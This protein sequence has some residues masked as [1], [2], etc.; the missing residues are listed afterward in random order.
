MIDDFCMVI[1][2]FATVD[3]HDSTWLIGTNGLENDFEAH[4]DTQTFALASR[5]SLQLFYNSIH[6][7]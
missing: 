5:G 7:D 2:D 6:T 1:L 4:T 3:N